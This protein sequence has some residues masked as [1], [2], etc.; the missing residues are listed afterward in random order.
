MPLLTS[1]L[2]FAVFGLLAAALVVVPRTWPMWFFV[3]PFLF[4][5]AF[6]FGWGI[7]QLF[8]RD[9]IAVDAT[10]LTVWSTRASTPS[11][12]IARAD[13]SRLDVQRFRNRFA[14][15]V[16]D[17]RAR[18]TVLLTLPSEAQARHLVNELERALA[19]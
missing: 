17:V 13:V 9:V 19:T 7:H 2:I 15:R 8:T 6:L 12:T 14:V 10:T 11:I 3:V 5:G 18:P 16:I 1:G 4:F